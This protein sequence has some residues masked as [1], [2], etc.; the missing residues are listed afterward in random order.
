V[1]DIAI[2]LK[3]LLLAS[4]AYSPG[5]AILFRNGDLHSLARSVS[6]SAIGSA[7]LVTYS[8]HQ[9]RRAIRIS[10][11]LLRGYLEGWVFISAS[12]SSN[13]ETIRAIGEPIDF[14]RPPADE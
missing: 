11:L 9:I 5:R 7:S 2:F 8:A 13:E 12:C 14:L 6:S 3:E 1:F 4:F 10:V